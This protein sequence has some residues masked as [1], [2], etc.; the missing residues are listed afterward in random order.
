[1]AK[2]LA[3]LMEKNLSTKNQCSPNYQRSSAGKERSLFEDEKNSRKIYSNAVPIFR[4]ES[5][6]SN[7]YGAENLIIITD[8]KQV[9]SGLIDTSSI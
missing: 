6:Y 7:K 5:F 9:N 4:L 2:G 3:T 8:S 1:M